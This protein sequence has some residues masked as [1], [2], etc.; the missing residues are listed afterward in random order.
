MGFDPAIAYVFVVSL[1]YPLC[2]LKSIEEPLNNN[3]AAFKY[4]MIHEGKGL[5]EDLCEYELN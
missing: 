4:Q 1:I 3:L 2:H 5:F